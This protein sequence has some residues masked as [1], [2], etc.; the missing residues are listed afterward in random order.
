MKTKKIQWSPTLMLILILFF[1]ALFGCKKDQTPQPSTS[2]QTSIVYTPNA[3]DSFKITFSYLS[4]NVIWDSVTTNY[5]LREY[6]QGPPYPSGSVYMYLKNTCIP[7]S[8]ILKTNDT[9]SADYELC[10]TQN[11]TIHLTRNIYKN[12]ILWK[13]NNYTFIA[14]QKSGTYTIPFVWFQ[15][16]VID[17]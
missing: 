11:D 6:N 16:V 15:D 1:V 3:I 4:P 10:T 2:A 12:N 5:S 8:F 7:V 13:S 14:N 17:N 9:L